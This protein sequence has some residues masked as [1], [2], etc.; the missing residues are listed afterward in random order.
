MLRWKQ[1]QSTCAGLDLGSGTLFEGPGALLEAKKLEQWDIYRP[2][3]TASRAHKT[4]TSPPSSSS[5]HR[6]PRKPRSTLLGVVSWMLI[7]PEG[8]SHSFGC[9]GSSDLW[10]FE[11]WVTSFP[12]V[13]WCKTN[14]ALK[15]FFMTQFTALERRYPFLSGRKSMRQTILMII[16]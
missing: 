11:N 2:A 1:K 16:H 3:L 9:E 14:K 4:S 15:T 12:L 5:T 7:R 8:V 13:P 6:S 10:S